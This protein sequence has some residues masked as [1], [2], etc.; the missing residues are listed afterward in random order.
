MLRN[1]ERLRSPQNVELSLRLV[2]P[3]DASEIGSE[4]KQKI[5][6]RVRYNV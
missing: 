4:V 1:R 6:D 3:E 2:E 5:M